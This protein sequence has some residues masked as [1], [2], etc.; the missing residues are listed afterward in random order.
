[1]FTNWGDD[2]KHLRLGRVVT[3]A[4]CVAASSMATL[5]TAKAGA[6]FHTYTIQRSS[7]TYIIAKAPDLFPSGADDSVV[8]LALPFPV[9]IYGVLHSNTWVSSNG[10]LQ[11]G[12]QPSTAYSNGCLPTSSL[13]SPVLAPYWDDLVL[14]PNP[15]SPDGVFTVT[16]GSAPHRKF[17]ISW[18]GVDYATQES[19]V[20]FEIVF[21][22]GKPY[23]DFVYSDGDGYS[24][25]IGVQKS[26][27]G[28]ATEFLC[29][30][31]KHNVVTPGEKLRFTYS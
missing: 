22:E 21:S 1:M 16:V 9:S 6:T 29:N 19:A 27:T 2:M 5:P 28:P 11:F 18:R 3:A 13:S 26:S 23:F 31:G 24:S 4:A 12:S 20:R 14:R 8:N 10:N 30:P 7:A 15:A 25:T 17:A